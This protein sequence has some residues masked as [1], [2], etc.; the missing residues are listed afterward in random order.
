MQK[1]HLREIFKLMITDLLPELLAKNGSPVI[2]NEDLSIRIDHTRPPWFAWLT[3]RRFQYGF[4]DISKKVIEKLTSMRDISPE[5]L[6]EDLCHIFLRGGDND[7]LALKLIQIW[8]DFRDIDQLPGYRRSSRRFRRINARQAPRS[9]QYV[10]IRLQDGDYAVPVTNDRTF[11][12]NTRSRRRVKYE[13][14]TDTGVEGIE[15]I[16]YSDKTFNEWEDVYID[17]VDPRPDVEVFKIIH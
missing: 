6:E 1:S 8:M 11:Y 16:D 4:L 14:M 12:D 7:I 2:V 9:E 15:L 13:D 3:G 5:G 10:Y 17:Y